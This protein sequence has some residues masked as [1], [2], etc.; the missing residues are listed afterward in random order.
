MICHNCVFRFSKRIVQ[1]APFKKAPGKIEAVF[2]C[3]SCGEAVQPTVC[4]NCRFE[5]N[6]MDMATNLHRVSRIGN[7]SK[8]A[9]AEFDDGLYML[10]ADF[11]QTMPGS[12]HVSLTLPL[13][14][15]SDKYE[16][17]ISGLMDFSENNG[18][19]IEIRYDDLLFRR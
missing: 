14:R 1:V 6:T 18:D 12:M 15:K 13:R 17:I 2:Q 7:V 3:P 5:W 10:G 9:A 11:N 8:W 4:P 16:V 19:S